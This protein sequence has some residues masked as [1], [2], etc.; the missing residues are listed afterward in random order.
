MANPNQKTAYRTP[1]GMSPYR[2]VFNKACHL[3]VEIEHKAYWAVKKCNMAYDQSGKERK[4]QL[5]ELEEL[6]LGL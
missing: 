4:L 1:L 5:Q 6:R 3:P 2:I